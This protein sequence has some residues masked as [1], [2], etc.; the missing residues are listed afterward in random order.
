[1][2]E[3]SS[4]LEK[5]L[6][7]AGVL[8]WRTIY[9]TVLLLF[10]CT[11]TQP[12]EAYSPCVSIT[13]FILLSFRGIIIKLMSVLYTISFTSIFQIFNTVN[14]N[15]SFTVRI[16]IDP[17]YSF[18]RTT[19]E[20]SETIIITLQA[21]PTEW[22]RSL[23]MPI[24]DRWRSALPEWRRSCTT[25][26]MLVPRIS[27]VRT[28]QIRCAHTNTAR[29]ITQIQIYIQRTFNIIINYPLL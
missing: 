4:H 10:Y 1:M 27:S 23:D 26:L 11:N 3:G 20:F 8:R 29:F 2:S 13:S 7:V 21:H 16:L 14:W 6:I 24:P 22:P 5:L 19:R 28:N 18:T 25:R 15:E 17:Q 9:C 12:Y